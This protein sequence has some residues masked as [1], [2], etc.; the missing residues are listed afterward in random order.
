MAKT[1]KKKYRM[2]QNHDRCKGCGSCILQ[3]PKECLSFSDTV[4]KKGYHIVT[5]DTEKCIT[6]GICYTVC[7]DYV[8]EKKEVV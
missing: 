5:L 4:N 6:C 2:V 1:E 7:P 3:C 8:F